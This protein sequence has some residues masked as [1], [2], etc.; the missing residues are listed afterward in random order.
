[1]RAAAK[2][3]APIH[4]SRTWSVTFRG[5]FLNDGQTD[6]RGISRG[7]ASLDGRRRHRR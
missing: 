3:F 1:M 6:R 7:Y 5:T 4:E 2:N